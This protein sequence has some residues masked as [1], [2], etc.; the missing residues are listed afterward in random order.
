MKRLSLLF[1]LFLFFSSCATGTGTDS[2]WSPYIGCP[3][4][5]L[6]QNWGYGGD[7]SY[8]SSDYGSTRQTYYYK[9]LLFGNILPGY[10]TMN[11]TM[12]ILITIED[13]EITSISYLSYH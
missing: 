2:S 6:Y 11:M 4:E 3:E 10:S 8:Y 7:S 12:N 9:N 5:E 1:L 13:G